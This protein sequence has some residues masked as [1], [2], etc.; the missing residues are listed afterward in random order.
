MREQNNYSY[1]RIS[2]MST[3]A[4]LSI[5]YFLLLT[6]WKITFIVISTL[7]IYIYISKWSML[8]SWLLVPFRCSRQ[9][10]PVVVA[11]VIIVVIVWLWSRLCVHIRLRG[12]SNVEQKTRKGNNQKAEGWLR[13]NGIKISRS[14]SLTMAR[15]ALKDVERRSPRERT[16]AC[17]NT[18]THS[19]ILV[20]CGRVEMS[21]YLCMCAHS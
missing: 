11:V 3:F 7:Y 5:F 14:T 12:V 15:A 1:K 9:W 18:P 17:S 19:L 13:W 20:P 8:R 16:F 2:P 6:Q 10:W 21:A 4:L